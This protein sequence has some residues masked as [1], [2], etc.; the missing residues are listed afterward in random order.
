MRDRREDGVAAVFVE[1]LVHAPRGEPA[2]RHLRFH[3]AERGLRKADV[4][5]EHA[6]ERVVELARLVDL[7]LVELQPLHPRIGHGG[8]GAEAGA[9]AA[10]VDPMRPH[11]R[12]HQELA[13]VEI[14]HVDDDIV[15]VLAGDRLVVGDDHVARREAVLAVA[16]H[17]VGDDD[18]EVGD[19]MRH[20][21]DIL[22]DQ[23]AVGVDQRGAEV[24]H[25]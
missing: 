15:E 21:A 25:S 19:E 11:H 9:H 1:Q 22:A 17:A 14:G 12:E 8:A 2:G 3:V 24:A 7:E 16:L 20:A 4:V 13:A 23:L 18:A 6:I 5:L 10:D